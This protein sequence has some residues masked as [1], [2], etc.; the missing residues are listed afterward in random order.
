MLTQVESAV[1]WH[2]G[3]GSGPGQ[4]VAVVAAGAWVQSEAQ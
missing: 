3:E 4:L 2:S 1:F